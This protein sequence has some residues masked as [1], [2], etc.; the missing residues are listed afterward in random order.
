MKKKQL[1]TAA[2]LMVSSV[3]F[4][5]G[6]LTNTNQNVAFNRNF[7]R[8]ATF[9][10]DGAYS[11]PAGLAWLGNGFHISVNWQT[12]AQ[13]RTINSNYKPFA[14]NQAN[15]SA[16]REFK[17]KA[18][19]PV[20]PSIQF[21][22]QK[23]DWTVS[24]N[25][26]IGG[27]GGKCEFADGLPMFESMVAGAAAQLAPAG[28]TGYTMNSCLEGEQYIYALQVGGTYRILNNL[29]SAKHG[30]SVYGGLRFNYVSNAY[31]GYMNNIN[32][33]I[34]PASPFAAM[35]TTLPMGKVLGM[36]SPGNPAAALLE[37][38]IE[39]D[40]SQSGWGLQPI[41]GLDYRVGKL[42]IGL[43]Y[44]FMCNVEV[45]NETKVNT[46]GLADYANGVMTD[47][48]IPAILSLGA[49]YE[50]LPQLRVM[51]GWTYYFDKDAE[52][53]GGKQKTLDHNTN[54]ILFG[55]E[56]DVLPR[57]T[58]SAGGQTTDFGTTDAFQND[59]AFSCDSYSLGLGAKVALTKK[60]DLNLAYFFTDYKDYSRQS[61]NHSGIDTYSR[62]NHVGG[63]GVNFHF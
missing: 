40:C 35:G 27:G 29:G 31:S 12:A 13:T 56:Y 1:L 14:L 37:N 22:W 11:N 38:G 30:L 24:M 2:V 39:L 5:G 17:G 16:D 19:A 58:L 28:V 43:R 6:L 50:I 48:D 60:I 23:N 59:L 57:L 36:A 26:A 47:N 4:A 54:E 33:S 51:A 20:I 7:A 63:I 15:P 32:A 21:A 34:S 3:T 53:A 44:E 9:E 55:V 45:E 46:A 25:F 41:V 61:A 18:F 42:N 10:I 49:Q 52:M 62:T 8:N